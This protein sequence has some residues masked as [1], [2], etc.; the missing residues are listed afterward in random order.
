MNVLQGYTQRIERNIETRLPVYDNPHCT[1]AAWRAAVAEGRTFK[2]YVQTV[3]EF[4]LSQE[5]DRGLPQALSRFAMKRYLGPKRRVTAVLDL[6]THG[7]SIHTKLD[8]VIAAVIEEAFLLMRPFA[9]YGPK[10]GVR[11]DFVVM[12]TDQGVDFGMQELMGAGD[13]ELLYSYD[14]YTPFPSI[15]EL[16]VRNA[17]FT[18]ADF[19]R[20][21]GVEMHNYP[22]RSR[23]EGL[24]EP[25]RQ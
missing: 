19:Q 8:V 3:T 12:Q 23:D 15:E 17:K 24:E 6:R 20:R 13:H 16:G 4:M 25:G 5:M 2:G 18:Y 14:G 9:V 21:P 1:L 11:A 22:D 7:Y 10:P